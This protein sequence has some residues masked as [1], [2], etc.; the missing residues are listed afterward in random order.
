MLNPPLASRLH[1]RKTI[2]IYADEGSSQASVTGWVTTLHAHFL[3]PR[4]IQI[5]LTTSSTIIHDLTSQQASQTVLIMP[6]GAD[7]PYIRALQGIATDKI[8]TMIRAG[9]T[10]IGTCAGAYFASLACIFEPN[11]STLRVI[12][13]RPLNLVPYPAVGAARTGFKYGSEDGATMETLQCSW[14]NSQFQAHIYCNGGPAWPHIVSST[15]ISKLNPSM[16]TSIPDES[17]SQGEDSRIE[18]SKTVI[19]ARYIHP[20]LRRHGITDDETP[21]AVVACAVGAGVAIVSGVHPEL[22]QHIMSPRDGTF[23]LLRAIFTA[24]RLAAPYV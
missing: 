21:A 3:D 20:V 4:V 5:R 12:G 22:T 13:L 16:S 1:L 19:I 15:T 14:D 11:D 8:R 6:G 18:K 9:A 24:A 7:L 17:I 2:Y 23:K 10:Y